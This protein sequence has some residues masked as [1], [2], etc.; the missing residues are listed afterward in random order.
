[1]AEMTGD[2]ARVAV[3]TNEELAVIFNADNMS[4]L[5]QTIRPHLEENKKKL[6]YLMPQANRIGQFSL[7]AH[8]LHSVH[9]DDHDE[10]L[11]IIN[12]G[13]EYHFSEGMMRLCAPYMKF[14]GSP[15]SN[16]T[17]RGFFDGPDQDF[18]LFRLVLLSP[19]QLQYL[20]YKTRSAGVPA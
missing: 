5:L 9:A 17:R 1:M 19:D 10:T 18:G 14:I 12:S 7:E 8:G 6:V 20:H 3:V 15:D 4:L 11:V 2:G 16:M 13:D